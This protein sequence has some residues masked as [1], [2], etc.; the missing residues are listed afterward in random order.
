MAHEGGESV[1]PRLRGRLFHA[2]FVLRRPMTL[3]VRAVIHDKQANSVL[4]IRHT[5]APGWHFPGGGIETGET[6]LTALRREAA[7][8]ANVEITSPPALRSFHFNRSASRRD[9]VAL[10]LVQDFQQTAPK[11]PDLEI[12]EAGFFALDALPQGVTAGT[13]RR[14][15][16]LFEGAPVSEEW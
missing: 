6:A 4:L 9:H 7:E 13:R 15:A 8:E 5:Y 10:F 3:G 14:I 2:W 1:W 11:K 12:A 16:E